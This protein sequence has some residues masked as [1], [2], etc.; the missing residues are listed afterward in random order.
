MGG[1]EKSRRGYYALFIT[2]VG[3]LIIIDATTNPEQNGE[4]IPKV[5]IHDPLT[6][7]G[8]EPGFA[9]ACIELF[10][11]AGYSVETFMGREVT[12][13]LL[14][15]VPK[16]CDAL[17]LRV[18]SGVFEDTVWLFTGERYDNAKHVMEQL[19]DELHIARITPNSDPLF[20]VGAKFVSRHMKGRLHDTLVVMMACEGL[21]STDLGEAFLGA[22]ASA[23]VSWDGLVS[24]SHTDEATGILLEGL[25]LDWARLEE[26]VEDTN[27]MVGGD[28]LYDS[29]LT[30]IPEDAEGIVLG[31]VRAAGV[32]RR[33]HTVTVYN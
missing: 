9:E 32:L 24:L 6:S 26:A 2:V 5:A 3:I 29:S 13:D 7:D 33:F 4:R 22:G 25:V 18:H 12:V 27:G 21:N 10:E 11:S 31:G 30:F 17:I 8:E 16:D 14:K 1:R 19:A 20:A 28:K 23:Y 15:R